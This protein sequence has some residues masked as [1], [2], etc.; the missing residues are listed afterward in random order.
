M[1]ACCSIPSEALKKKL[2]ERF[3]R[4]FYVF[5]KIEINLPFVEALNQMPNYVKFLND[6]LSKKG[7][8]VEKGVVN[9]TSICSVVIQRSLPEKM[10]DPGSFTIP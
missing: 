10:Q 5:K 1:H 3:S 2:E 6:I 7:K 9:L 8:F 4:F